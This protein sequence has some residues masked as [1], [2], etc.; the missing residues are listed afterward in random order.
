MPTKNVAII[1]KSGLEVNINQTKVRYGEFAITRDTRKVFVG[2]TNG[3]LQPISSIPN[4]YC[5]FIDMTGIAG[6]NIASFP[7]FNIR[8]T[9]ASAN[10]VAPVYLD[11]PSVRSFAIQG[12]QW[13]NN[14]ATESLSTTSSAISYQIDNN[15]G[16]GT[17]PN[18]Y[19]L[20]VFDISNKKVYRVDIYCAGSGHLDTATTVVEEFMPN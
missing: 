14:A 4:K 16:Y 2:D 20:S 15:T 12:L 17:N 1:L 19:M 7:M 10:S 3:D 6:E 18:W 9:K 13:Y 8:F 11:W 5:K